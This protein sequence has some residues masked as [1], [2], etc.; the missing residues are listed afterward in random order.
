MRVARAVGA[1]RG[2]IGAGPRSAAADG[3]WRQR[4]CT[5]A[6]DGKSQASTTNLEATAEAAPAIHAVDATQPEPPSNADPVP[7]SSSSFSTTSSSNPASANHA[8]AAASLFSQARPSAPLRQL[9]GQAPVSRL[10]I[11]KDRPDARFPAARKAPELPDWLTGSEEQ[12]AAAVRERLSRQ[13]AWMQWEREQRAAEGY[14]SSSDDEDAPAGA[15]G[16]GLPEVE[17]I[18]STSNAYVKHLVKLRT[19]APY[20]RGVR[21]VLLVGR[22]LV[23]EAAG[24]GGRGLH[25]RVLLLPEGP[26]A[27]LRGVE[28]D[29][30]VRVTEAVMKKVT[31]VEN[32]GGVTAVAE[33]A[34]PPER[35]LA[36]LLYEAAGWGAAAAREAAAEADAEAAAAVAAAEAEAEE[37]RAGSSAGASSSAAP[38]ALPPRPRGGAPPRPVRL[39]VL[40]GVQ[41]PG[42]LGTLA[43][44]A[45]AFGWDGLFLLPGCVDPAN[46]K[47]VRSSRGATLRLPVASG[48]LEELAA[49]AE[50]CGLLLLSADL[51]E[52]EAQGKAQVQAQGR[53][54]EGGEG[55]GEGEGEGEGVGVSV[56][57]GVG[58]C[59]MPPPRLLEHG[60]LLGLLTG[61][62]AGAD[63]CGAAPGSGST[64][65]SGSGSA[66]G[67]GSGS[68]CGGVS[69]SGGLG[70]VALVLGAEGAGLSPGVRALCRRVSIPMEGSMES[71]NVGVAGGIL[72][73]ALSAGMPP[74]LSK[75][76]TRLAEASA[77]QQ[78]SAGAA[79]GGG[80]EGGAGGG[81]GEAAGVQQGVALEGLQAAA[82]AAAGGQ[83]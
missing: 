52:G 34:L 27:P 39:L 47:A 37:G 64:P 62:A 17:L 35:S 42:N 57:R 55:A 73:F 5:L 56:G 14:C 16:P 15:K 83:A 63:L 22:E 44:S 75:L 20:R 7:D 13:L 72:M 80:A 11:G 3:L 58:A 81:G 82:Q 70:G 50:A 69:R 36:Q 1:F 24:E 54:Q 26:A 8:A 28:A 38:V 9:R 12:R 2:R 46:D 53:E 77:A 66:S 19:S 51:E 79:E 25:A 67:S 76:A 30:V 31:G 4:L 33:V 43:R 68:G 78:G 40:D 23:E 74:L 18:T 71:L 61:A 21:R 65:S 60:G 48:S 29:K 32:A 6:A 49:A 10:G 41:D 59:P 45:L